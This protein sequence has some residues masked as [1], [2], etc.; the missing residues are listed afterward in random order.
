MCGKHV[1]V[2]CLG[3]RFREDVVDPFY[4]MANSRSWNRSTSGK[5]IPRSRASFDHIHQ[6]DRLAIR[7]GWHHLDIPGSVNVEVPATPTI[8][9]VEGYRGRN[10]PGLSHCEATLCDKWLG[11]TPKYA[12]AV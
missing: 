5:A 9:I 3:D 11:S 8:D 10:I 4:S 2:I 6:V 12:V 1:W 7:V